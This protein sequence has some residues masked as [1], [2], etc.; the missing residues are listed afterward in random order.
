MFTMMEWDAPDNCP[1]SATFGGVT[2]W[3]TPGTVNILP[4]LI[5]GI[6]RES[7][8]EDRRNTLPMLNS[9]PEGQPGRLPQTGF[10]ADDDE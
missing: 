9:V 6:L 2:Y 3:I 5:V 4:N 7:M 10:I 1:H 8:A